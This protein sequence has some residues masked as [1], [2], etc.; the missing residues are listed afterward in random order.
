MVNPSKDSVM[1]QGQADIV[2]RLR[3]YAG[4]LCL[5]SYVELEAAQEIERLRKGNSELLKALERLD[6]YYRS[7]SAGDEVEDWVIFVKDVLEPARAAI[8]KARGQA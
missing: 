1:E 7:P 8:T 6:T 4:N 5:S 3:R 2:E